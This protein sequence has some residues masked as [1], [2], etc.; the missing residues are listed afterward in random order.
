EALA[1]RHPTRLDP[2]LLDEAALVRDA[3]GRAADLAYLT[4]WALADLLAGEITATRRRDL[5]RRLPRANA[6]GAVALV[7]DELADPSSRGLGAL[8]PRRLLAREQ[9]GEGGGPLPAVGQEG[10]GGDAVLPRL[11]PPVHVDWQT[12]RAARRAYL[13]ALWGFVDALAPSF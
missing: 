7:A 13:D 4:D 2:A 5:L 12:D 8:P 10:A 6:P 1:Q 3:L 9:L 11:R